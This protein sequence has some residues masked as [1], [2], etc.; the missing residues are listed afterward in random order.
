MFNYFETGG[1]ERFDN[2][3]GLKKVEIQ[4]YPR[5]EQFLHVNDH[6][7]NMKRDQ[8]KAVSNDDPPKLL[9]DLSELARIQMHDGIERDGSRER[10]VA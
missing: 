3:A 1:S 7:P 5:S 4:R 6:I 10:S 9:Q 2:L 8:H